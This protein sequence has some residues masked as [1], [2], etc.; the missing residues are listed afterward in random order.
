MAL[1]FSLSASGAPM[2]N[3]GPELKAAQKVGAQRVG[4][5]R[6]GAQRVGAQNV[7]PDYK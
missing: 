6:V 5:Q 3:T 4:A 1:L 7:S 2:G